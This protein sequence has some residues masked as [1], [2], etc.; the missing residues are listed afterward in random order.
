MRI[1]DDKTV[2]IKP[3]KKK[4]LNFEQAIKEFIEER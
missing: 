2:V 4:Y 1:F 3:I